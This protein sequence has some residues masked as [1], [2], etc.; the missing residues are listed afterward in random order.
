MSSRLM[1]TLRR[2]V[3]RFNERRALR[4]RFPT[5]ELDR[6]VVIKG[7]IA[8]IRLGA[9]VSI[10]AG[11]FLHL[12]GRPWCEN[13]GCLEIGNDSVISPHCVIYGCGSGGVR[14][15]RRLDC[16]PGVGIFASRT[17]Y[18]ARD[19]R[20]LFAPVVIGDDVIIYANAVI[21]PG[22]RID[23]GAVIAACSVVTRDVPANALVA[24]SP[25]AVVEEN[26]RGKS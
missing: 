13:A 19:G 21:S 26:V 11:T 2:A 22:V 8:N 15:G 7:D 16:G 20:H 9:N 3:R 10:M 23:D 25:A 18:R 5:A 24:G 17:D 12:G 1:R 4:R 14:I 6:T